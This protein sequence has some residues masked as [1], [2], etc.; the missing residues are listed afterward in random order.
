MPTV[1]IVYNNQIDNAD[2]VNRTGVK[3]PTSI[4]TFTNQGASKGSETGAPLGDYDSYANLPFYAGFIPK[5]H[6][7]YYKPTDRGQALI[8]DAAKTVTVTYF[9][10]KLRGTKSGAKKVTTK[11]SLLVQPPSTE[12]FYLD[13]NGDPNII[14]R[15]TAMHAINAKLHPTA[16]NHSSPY[17]GGTTPNVRNLFWGSQYA[18]GQHKSIA[19]NPSKKALQKIHANNKTGLFSELIAS[20]YEIT[21]DPI[22]NVIQIGDNT[23][24]TLPHCDDSSGINEISEDDW[25]IYTGFALE[26]QTMATYYSQADLKTHFRASIAKK[27]LAKL[28]ADE[29]EAEQI[30]KFK[31]FLGNVLSLDQMINTMARP[32]LLELFSKEEVVGNLFP[33]DFESIL[34]HLTTTQ[35]ED[36][37]EY[38]EGSIPHG[39]VVDG[40]QLVTDC[41][42]GDIAEAIFADSTLET[43]FLAAL[44]ANHNDASIQAMALGIKNDIKDEIANVY[45]K[46]SQG[47][48]YKATAV[49]YLQ[50]LTKEQL[51]TI[52]LTYDQYAENAA[53]AL[54]GIAVHTFRSLGQVHVPD[55]TGANNTDFDQL[56]VVPHTNWDGND[57]VQM[58]SAFIDA[59]PRV[60][61]NKN[62]PFAFSGVKY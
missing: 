4:T 7:T 22:N 25:D 58:T 34:S 40:W 38:A 28:F 31:S 59:P 39:L 46:S 13:F 61:I 23:T 24:P 36:I 42:P 5:V 54:H 30:A 10:S 3:S 45:V 29:S 9:Q 8:N 35:L 51:A 56:N 6:L 20:N 26:Y 41:H 33:I 52:Q 21:H 47:I 1:D 27:Q 32:K 14:N 12:L 18:N 62:G 49:K 44:D 15:Q 55:Y 43:D 16:N 19:E 2:F 60:R 50:F 37:Y 11:A 53:T 17:A 48:D 57:L